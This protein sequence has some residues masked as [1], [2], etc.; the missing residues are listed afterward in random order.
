MGSPSSDPDRF[1]QWAKLQGE[2]AINLAGSFP[3]DPAI[4]N[5]T[6][7]GL[8]PIAGILDTTTT[9]G[10]AT[11][12]AATNIGIAEYS[13]R[14]LFSDDTI[15]KD[16]AY[17][18]ITQMELTQEAGPDGPEPRSYLRKSFAPGPIGYRAAVSTSLIDKLPVNFPTQQLELDD[19]VMADYGG[20][21]FPRAIGYSAG[22]IDYFF[23]G[24][25]ETDVGAVFQSTPDSSPPTTVTM[26]NVS[27]LTPDEETGNGGTLTLVL[28]LTAKFNTSEEIAANTISSEMTANVSRLPVN[29]TFA[30]SSLPFPSTMGAECFP[31]GSFICG[32]YA[33]F[34]AIMIYRG[35][36]GEEADAVAVS[37][38]AV[39]LM[40]ERY[41]SGT[42]TSVYGG[43][44]CSG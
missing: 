20:L 4:L 18:N 17:P 6:Y 2:N 22:L 5:Q 40:L 35:P 7:N 9:A 27:N 11:P 24:N 25:I 37:R 19:N 21:L 33:R 39:S 42:F 41:T 30:F 16:Y 12:S 3:F 10:P 1:H 14:K 26:Y 23:R 36:L 28:K 13:K 29:T 43:E 15:L 38:C 32:S 8:V 31:Q 34:E 44:A